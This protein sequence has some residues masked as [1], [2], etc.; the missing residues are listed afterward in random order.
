VQNFV[1]RRQMRPRC[2]LFNPAHGALV[3]AIMLHA[4]AGTASAVEAELV[5]AELEPGPARTVVRII[6]GE[7]VSLDDGSE[8]RLIG[9]LV[10]RIM[11]VDAE[12]G[13]WP[14][15]AAATEALRALVLGKSIELRFGPVRA[16]RYGRLQAHAFLIEGDGRRWI[17]GTLLQEG[18]A[19]AYALAADRTC[20]EDLLA[21]ERS[22]RE[23][24]RALW[25]QAA[26]QVRSADNPADLM[27]YRATFQIVEGAI[28]RVA[29]LRE[30]IYLNFDHNWRRG[31][32][33]SLRRDDRALLGAHAR[34]PKALEGRTVRVRGWIDQRGGAPV[35]DLSASGLIE[36]TELPAKPDG[37]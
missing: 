23:A 8:L 5:C 18:H 21:A 33:V 3:V 16:D 24:R 19:R 25:A 30:T 9:A 14:M 34:D 2:P 28:V 22:A 32:S 13:A 35:I 4:L 31:F 17:Q 15:E 27:R 1:M 10:P 11:D 7:T 29:Q 6:D 12:P 20:A 26:Y 36:V 37:R